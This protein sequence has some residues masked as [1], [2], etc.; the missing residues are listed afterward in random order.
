[1]D[2]HCERTGSPDLAGLAGLLADGTRA[3]LGLDVGERPE[4]AHHEFS[5]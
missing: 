5:R 4:F 2:S 1:M 3:Q